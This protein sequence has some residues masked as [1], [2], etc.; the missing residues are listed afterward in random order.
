MPQRPAAT[1]HLPRIADG[2]ALTTKDHQQPDRSQHHRPAAGRQTSQRAAAPRLTCPGQEESPEPR[3]QKMLFC[4]P[5]TDPTAG[6]VP[7]QIGGYRVSHD[8]GAVTVGNEAPLRPGPAPSSATTTSPVT[9]RSD[10]HDHARLR[11]VTRTGSPSTSAFSRRSSPIAASY[12]RSAARWAGVSPGEAFHMS[13]WFWNSTRSS[14]WSW[15]TWMIRVTMASSSR[16]GWARGRLQQIELSGGDLNPLA[17]VLG[18]PAKLSDG[19]PVLLTLAAHP[20]SVEPASPAQARICPA[21]HAGSVHG[22]VLIG[23]PAG[24]GTAICNGEPCETPG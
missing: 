22:V 20:P 21:R 7:V 24:G 16:Y 8:S 3:R 10:H 14:A 13:A 1:D 11:L 17:D 18:K 9:S 6:S 5:P 19:I 15:C 2:G 4:P 12:S 23:T